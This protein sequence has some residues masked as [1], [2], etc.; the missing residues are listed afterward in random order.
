MRRIALSLFVGIWLAAPAAALDG[1]GMEDL[2]GTWHVLV[3][4]KDSGAG[5]PDA[6]RWEDRIW[7][8]ELEGSRVKWTDYPIVVFGNSSGRFEATF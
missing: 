8:F 4:Y 6:R 7:V 2:L 1:V 5:N 3:H